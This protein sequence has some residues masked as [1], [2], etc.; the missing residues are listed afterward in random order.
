MRL[1]GLVCVAAGALLIV[2]CGGSESEDTTEPA[3]VDLVAPDEFAE[4]LADPKAL[5][6]NVHVPYEGEIAG[7]DLFVPFDEIG[8][9]EALPADRDR[10][11]VVYCR[12]GNMSAQATADLVEAGY[13]DVTDLEGGMAAWAEDGRAIQ[14]LPEHADP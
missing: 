7:T 11:L 13:R 2:G 12:S 10:P 14:V 1:S 5:V 9:S 8:S 3:E 6:I 4:R